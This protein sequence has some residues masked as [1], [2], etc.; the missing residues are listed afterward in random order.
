MEKG[1][2]RACLSVGNTKQPSRSAKF[3]YPHMDTNWG[4]VKDRHA[5]FERCGV[6]R[7]PGRIAPGKPGVR[8]V[9]E[10]RVIQAACGASARFMTA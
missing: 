5:A 3:R 8:S 4:G 1:L 2:K 7:C 10:I 9:P 6:R